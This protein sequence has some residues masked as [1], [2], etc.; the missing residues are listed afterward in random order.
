MSD[1]PSYASPQA[2]E[3]PS[4]APAQADDK[5]RN[6]IGTVALVVAIVGFIFACIPGAL[7]LGWILLP[8]AF[9][10][11]IV[12]LAQSGK[13]KGTSIAA[14]I[15]SIVGTIVGVLVV[16]FG[17]ASA[18]DDAFESEPVE[19]ISPEEQD[20]AEAQDDAADEPAEA[21]PV[22][23]DEA[24][25]SDEDEEEGD[26]DPEGDVG[27]RSNPV[28]LGDTFTSR[29]WE[30]TVVSFNPD[31]TDEVLAANQF[32]EDPESGNVYALAEVEVTY[33][34]DDS[35]IPWIDVSVA[36]VTEGGNVTKTSDIGLVSPS[37]SFQDI[38][39]LYEGA[40]DS[41]YKAFEIPKGE[42]GLL[43]ITPGIFGDDVFVTTK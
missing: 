38:G 22:E 12:G 11:S 39:E 18:I 4:P 13:K 40:S 16:L 7:I 19:V 20:E 35:G 42:E 43:R 15:L 8:I 29:D 41:G 1:H 31:A 36:Y 30:V 5:Q 28:A 26:P 2:P 27:S 6:T 9:V 25:V 21:E 3:P 33:I 32:N 10:L 34:G 14:I 17:V 24:E 23:A 37:P